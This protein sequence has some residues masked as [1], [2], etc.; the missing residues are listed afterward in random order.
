MISTIILLFIVDDDDDNVYHF[1]DIQDNSNVDDGCD[2]LIIL[3]MAILGGWFL[4]SMQLY[5]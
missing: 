2:N 1:D 3:K 5:F 4:F